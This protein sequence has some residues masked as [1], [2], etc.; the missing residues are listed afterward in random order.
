[1]RLKQWPQHMSFTVA[2]GLG[3]FSANHP[4]GARDQS[5]R[6]ALTCGT[7]GTRQEAEEKGEEGSRKTKEEGPKGVAGKISR[8]GETAS[9]REGGAGQTLDSYV[10]RCRDRLPPSISRG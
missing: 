8:T 2:A 1:M 10:H 6:Y 9:P 7:P 3:V 4:R 5:R